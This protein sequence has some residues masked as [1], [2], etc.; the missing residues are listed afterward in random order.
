MPLTDQLDALNGACVDIIERIHHD[1]VTTRH[2]TWV[3]IARLKSAGQ[4]LAV[5]ASAMGVIARLEESQAGAV[6]ANSNA[7]L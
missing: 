2:D 4:D 3:R 1:A 7:S 5:I 6:E